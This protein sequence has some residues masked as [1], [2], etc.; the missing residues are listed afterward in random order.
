MQAPIYD[1]LAEYRKKNRISFAM[2]GHKSGRGLGVNFQQCDVTE[3]RATLNLYGDDDTVKR[4]N[5]MLSDF[6]GTRESFILPGGSTGAIQSMLASV[7]KPGD[8]LLATSDC[9]MSVINT[10]AIL[11]VNL[12]IL[13]ISLCGEFLIPTGA[14]EIELTPDIS[15]VLLTSPN[16]YGITKNIKSAAEKC[17]KAGI[18]L[19]VDEAH[20][21]H[22]TGRN[23]LPQSAVS[24]GADL[25]C[26][27]AHKTL[28]ALTGGAYL[29]VCTDRVEI[30][31]VKRAI[32]TFHSSS[33]SYPISASADYARAVLAKTDYSGIIKECT[34]FKNAISRATNICVFKNDDPT[35]IVLNFGEYDIT[36]QRVSEL[37][38]ERYGV[39][40]EMADLVN[41]VLIVTPENTHGDFMALFHALCEIVSV[42]K[43]AA[44]RVS[45]APPPTGLSIVSPQRAWFAKTKLVDLKRS[46]GYISAATVTAYPPGAAIIVTGGRVSREAV[47]YMEKIISEGADTVGVTD[48]KIE[49]VDDENSY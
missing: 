10:C 2:P 32:R 27:S 45:I 39:D 46:V 26:Q 37:L 31:R 7:L 12:K 35:R 18:P 30:E 29:H 11:G 13:Q 42:T 16:Y 19:L 36:G 40:I 4:A 33:P 34:D 49:V 15:A 47:E 43:S 14:D 41:I 9:H 17:R 5:S 6:Y 1:R 44:D 38:S 22:F 23:G 21:A 3:L 20:G 28:N 48:G 24:L 25:V 8:T